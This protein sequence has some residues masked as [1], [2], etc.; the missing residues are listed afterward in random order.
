MRLTTLRHI[1]WCT[2]AE[3]AARGDTVSDLFSESWALARP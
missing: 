2:L 1:S 3:P